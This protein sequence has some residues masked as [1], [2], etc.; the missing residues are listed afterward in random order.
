MLETRVRSKK[1]FAE[2]PESS[3]LLV[4]LRP[5]P[6]SHGSTL[7]QHCS[8]SWKNFSCPLRTCNK[9]KEA[10]TYELFCRGMDVRG[11]AG[12]KAYQAWRSLNCPW[13]LSGPPTDSPCVAST[14]RGMEKLDKES[15]AQAAHGVSA[16]KRG[17]NIEPWTSIGVDIQLSPTPRLLLLPLVVVGLSQFQ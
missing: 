8:V 3:R 7:L 13:A 16:L 11:A 14:P 12:V 17:S 15:N 10:Y 5:Q 1:Y 9:K 4:Y 2:N 6:S